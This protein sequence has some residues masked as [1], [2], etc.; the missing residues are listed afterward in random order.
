[1]PLL[2]YMQIF[3]PVEVCFTLWLFL[4]HCIYLYKGQDSPEYGEQLGLDLQP[5]WSL[6]IIAYVI[7]VIKQ[8]TYMIT[9]FN[10]PHPCCL[11]MEAFKY[12]R[13]SEVGE[14]LGAQPQA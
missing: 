2:Q 1:M 14:A 7:M 12:S 3:K 5:Y 6:T 8:S 9:L 10:E 11:N 13:A 4:L